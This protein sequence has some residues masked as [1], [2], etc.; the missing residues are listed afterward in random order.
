[1]RFL[2]SL[3]LVLASAWL[4]SSTT[5]LPP[6]QLHEFKL[7]GDVQAFSLRLI[8][9]FPFIEGEVNGQKGKFMFDTGNSLTLIPNNH[10]LKLPPG[11][12][13]G[14]GFTGS[15]QHFTRMLHDTIARVSLSNGLSYQDLLKIQSIP[16][17]FLE[18]LTPDCIGQ[19]GFGYVEGYIL[20]LDYAQRQLTCYQQTAARQASRDYLRGERVVAVLDIETRKR[21]GN[22]LA[23]VR[24][25]G[26]PFLCN[27]DT[28]Q[29]GGIYL[30]PATRRTLL[31]QRALVLLPVHEGDSLGT[32]RAV[33][34][35]AGFK[36]DAHAINLMSERNK[37]MDATLGLT[38]EP[39]V[40]SLG[41][42]FLSQF[43]TIWDSQ[44][45]KMYVCAPK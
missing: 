10:L 31:A 41:Y 42:A 3:L 38:N 1:M 22:V 16:F 32:L 35:A 27:F 30:D 15:G 29:Q 39:H 28:G 33:E 45:G 13:L 25:G 11:Q 9:A 44:A 26:I 20:K 2:N 37:P 21:P 40:M 24:I 7:R 6:A 19:I 18:Q 36:I 12:P 17:D 34:L 4:T 8:D 23:K 43:T 5:P 14:Q